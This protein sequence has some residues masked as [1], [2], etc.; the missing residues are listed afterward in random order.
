[1]ASH[2]SR[3]PT[4]DVTYD[5]FQNQTK[6]ITKNET[7]KKDHH[8]P[9]TSSTLMYYV[10]TA[11]ITTDDYCSPQILGVYTLQDL[12]LQNARCFFEK[13][14]ETYRDGTFDNK[15]NTNES[16]IGQD[17]FSSDLPV[18]SSSSS[19]DGFPCSKRVF[20]EAYNGSPAPNVVVAINVIRGN[21]IA[22]QHVPLMNSKSK[23]YLRH[24]DDN[25]VKPVQ[26]E[27]PAEMVFNNNNNNENR[28]KVFVVMS[29][30]GQDQ[31]DD[32]TLLG[33][34]REKDAAIATAKIRFETEK[35]WFQNRFKDGDFIDSTDNTETIG[36]QRG[37]LLS[38]IFDDGNGYNYSEYVAMDVFVLDSA[39]SEEEVFNDEVYWQPDICDFEEIEFKKQC[40]ACK[41]E[42]SADFY[43][44]QEWRKDGEQDRVCNDCL[45]EMT[46]VCSN[47]KVEK[48]Y[49]CFTRQEWDNNV[50]TD[51][52]DCLEEMTKPCSHC[53]EEKKYECY[54]RDD[55]KKNGQ[56]EARFCKVCYEV[57]NSKMCSFCNVQTTRAG[58][59]KGEYKKS[60]QQNRACRQCV[61]LKK[62]AKTKT[63]KCDAPQPK[64]G[65][66][67][68]ER[69]SIKCASDDSKDKDHQEAIMTTTAPHQSTPVQP[70][71]SKRPLPAA[72][73]NE[74]VDK[75]HNNN[76][77]PKLLDTKQCIACKTDKP[78]DD[79]S[80]TQWK[81]GTRRCKTCIGTSK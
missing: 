78:V 39:F 60:D 74:K 15:N 66:T 28:N 62:N 29:A 18:L 64:L 2:P 40:S 50:S 52:S 54:R 38:F 65:Q 24:S 5:I 41:V 61:L 53:K 77:K 55:W 1:L 21:E 45:P 73:T 22:S 76:K 8:Q 12:A 43:C 16:I 31:I 6:F 17:D 46:K 57:G 32:P 19:D 26:E 44:T 20:L 58:F 42:N 23:R 11:L 13:H 3:D 25:N 34:F 35:Q 69:P 47:C 30:T 4:Y 81:K 71:G 75:S 70:T 9:P 79:F 10:V 27:A 48:K 36:E 59:H 7:V 37:E 51:C 14:S 33:V 68:Q 63:K 80:K 67:D 56:D 72:V 49:V